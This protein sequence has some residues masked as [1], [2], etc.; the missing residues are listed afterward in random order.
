MQKKVFNS[1][2]LKKRNIVN[3]I[4]VVKK[5]STYKGYRDDSDIAFIEKK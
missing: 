2:I 3:L 1:N 5:I 4:G